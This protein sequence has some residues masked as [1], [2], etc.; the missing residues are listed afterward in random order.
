MKRIIYF[1][2]PSFAV[3]TLEKLCQQ[4]TIKV[5]AVI[6]QPDRPAGR[7]MQLTSTPVKVAAQKAGL[8]VYESL[9][10]VS[11]L[12]FDYGVVVAYGKFIPESIFLKW[13][14]VNLH[15]SLLPKYRGPSPMQSALL[16]GDAE[17]GVT[18]MLISKEMD[19]GDILMQQTIP[20]EINT[21]IAELHD[22]CAYEGAD[23]IVKTLEQDI[24]KIRKPQ[25]NTVAV[26]CK[27]IE[28]ADSE[29]VSTDTPEKIHNKVRAI[30]GFMMHRGKRVKILKTR[31]NNGLQIELVQPEGKPPMEYNAFINGYGALVL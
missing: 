20:L 1:G 16:N 9:D 30:G 24:E 25:D 17:T 15:P 7:G 31:W 2:S 29:I 18:T 21:T 22:R 5:V 27:K 3:P 11:T 26:F 12:T 28:N 10:I 8:P 23:L 19:A 4:S 13:P 6:T 14:C